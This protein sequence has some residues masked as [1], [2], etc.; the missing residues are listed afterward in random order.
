MLTSSNN[1]RV[2]L[3]NKTVVQIL[4]ELLA[5]FSYPV[6]RHQI[7]MRPIERATAR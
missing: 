1:P 5:D 6:D 3:Q 4:D 2:V 7:A